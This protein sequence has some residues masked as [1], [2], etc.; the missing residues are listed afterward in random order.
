MTGIRDRIEKICAASDIAPRAGSDIAAALADLVRVSDGA[1][2]GALP[3]AGVS[4][5]GALS[6][7]WV[8]EGQGITLFL[9]G[10]GIYGTSMKTGPKDHYTGYREFAVA[11]AVP[12]NVLDMIQW[13][14]GVVP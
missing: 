5:E 3:W 11:D 12:P 13:A 1:E 7:Q 6:V 14:S 9:C 2:I 8:R 4:D 10:D